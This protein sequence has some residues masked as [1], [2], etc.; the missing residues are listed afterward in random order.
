M[1]M[2]QPLTEKIPQKKW[3]SACSLEYPFVSNY[4]YGGESYP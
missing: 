4:I 3:K 1:E 2:G